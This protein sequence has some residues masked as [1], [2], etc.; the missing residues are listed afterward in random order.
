MKKI[1]AVIDVQNDFITGSLANPDA[2]KAVPAI[3]RKI[4][5]PG[6]DSVFV[7][8]DTHG[9]DYL[10][11]REGQKL[12][13]THCI[14]GTEGWKIQEDVRQALGRLEIPVTYIEKPGFG[15]T[16]LPDRIQEFI[17]GDDCEIV[18]VGFVSSICLISNAL[19]L[20]TSLYDKAEISIDASCTAGLNPENNSAALEVARSCQ[21]NVL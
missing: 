2:L 7:T 15:S 1:L 6:W 16:E 11:S 10:S 3:V 14:K 13:V 8:I 18:M 20:K 9:P 12:V 17:A 4:N 21:I 19:I 5:S